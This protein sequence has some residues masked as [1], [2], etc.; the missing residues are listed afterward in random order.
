MMTDINLE[1]CKRLTEEIIDKLDLDLSGL[2]VLTEA[3]TNLFSLTAPLA[4]MAGARSVLVMAKGSRYGSQE[5][6]IEQTFSVAK[7]WKCE[8]I[9]EVVNDLDSP[10]IADVD[11]VTNLAALRPLNRKFIEKLKPEA[12][13]P[14]MFETW[15]YR[16]E[17]LDLNACQEKGILVLGTNERHAEV[18]VLSYVGAIAIK[19]VLDVGVE[20]YRAN[21]IVLGSGIF[22]QEAQKRLVSAGADVVVIP[23]SIEGEY[24]ES[25]LKKLLINA[26]VLL[27]AEHVCKMELLGPL[28]K[29]QGKDIKRINPG[30]VIAHISG[31]VDQADL[32]GEEI[33]I[34]PNKFAPVGYMTVTTAYTGPAPI[35]RLHAAGLKVGQIMHEARINTNSQ[36]EAIKRALS[37]TLCQDFDNVL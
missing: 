25:L 33:I 11:I 22:A 1:R 29:T 3:A 28:S 5:N 16:E 36:E 18:D 19:L 10:K 20:V 21:I 23:V 26:D 7:H 24:D 12:V 13:V 9:I 6:A 14:L 35:I 32:V 4:A 2:T 17:D 30:V 27:I 31:N 15:E 34:Y 37:N 8:H